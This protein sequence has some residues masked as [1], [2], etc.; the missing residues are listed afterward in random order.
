MGMVS[1]TPWAAG[2]RDTKQRA[3]EEHKEI[4]TTMKLSPQEETVP[5]L[6]SFA[7]NTIMEDS[8]SPFSASRTEMNNLEINK[9]LCFQLEEAKQ[10]LRDLKE[11]LLISEATVYSLANQLWKYSKF[12]RLVVTQVVNEE[13]NILLK[14]L[15][16]KLFQSEQKLQQGRDVSFLLSQHLKDLLTQDD[17]SDEQAPGFQEQLAKGCWL[18]ECLVLKLSPG[19][20]ED[21]GNDNDCKWLSTSRLS[22]EGQEETLKETLENSLDED[23]RS[24]S[25]YI[26]LSKTHHPPSITDILLDDREESSLDAAR[27]PDDKRQEEGEKSMIFRELQEVEEITA[28]LQ[29]SVEEVYL[30]LSSWHDLSDFHQPSNSPLSPPEEQVVCSN[31]D[32]N[33]NEIGGKVTGGQDA[34]A[35]REVQQV[36][37]ITAVL[38]HSVD[39]IYLDHSSCYDLCD[40]HQTPNTPVSQHEEQFVC[41]ILDMDENEIGYKAGERQEAK[42]PSRELQEVED[43]TAVLQ[44]SVD[45]IYLAPSSCQDLCD[46]HQTPNTPASTPEQQVVSCILDADENK[47][48]CKAQEGQEAKYPVRELQVVE[49]ITTVLQ[50]S[51]DEVYLAPSSCQD[52]CDFHQT[53][54]TPASPP[55]EQFECCILDMDENKIGLNA[56]E[57]QDAKVSRELHGDAS[58][59]AVQKDSLHEQFLAPSS[60][61]DL[62]EFHQPPNTPSFLSEEYMVHSPLAVS[63]EYPHC[64]EN[65]APNGLPCS[66]PIFY[67]SLLSV[68]QLSLP[69]AL[70]LYLGFSQTLGVGFKHRHKVGQA[71]CTLPGFMPHFS[72][73]YIGKCSLATY[74]RKY[75]ALI[76]DQARELTQLRQQLREGREASLSL[77]QY[78]KDLLT[79]KDLDFYHGQGCQ[80]QLDEGHRLLDCL[81]CKLSAGEVAM[82]LI[83]TSCYKVFSS[84]GTPHLH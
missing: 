9:K 2:A 60:C 79:Q 37:D 22:K 36:E 42:A 47:I 1:N 55:E 65:K 41:C 7:T 15:A 68:R 49:D 3:W 71:A 54:K 16:Q 46:F 70:L 62:S 33:E 74:F 45:E 78:L 13:S 31:L 10:Q 50:H 38:Q 53:T 63:G 83:T 17:S 81:V 18:A 11:K 14:D 84:Q 20:H 24:S 75:C 64:R 29:Y 8:S 69:Q 28:M 57:G 76:H 23:L 26:D 5:G 82:V 21:E 58:L 4:V 48:G 56:G 51:Q 6:D 72:P 35:D 67:L 43:I 52:L 12:C 59:S 80:E 66:L 30:T 19:N 77:N 40:F 61:H 39:E 34:K 25:N 32:A 44:H 27:T 73:W